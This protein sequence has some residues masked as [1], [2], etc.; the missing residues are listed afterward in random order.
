MCSHKEMLVSRKANG[1]IVAAR[2]A[3]GESQQHNAE[4]KQPGTKE[5]ALCNH[6]KLK[7]RGPNLCRP[8]QGHI[9]FLCVCVRAQHVCSVV[10]AHVRLQRQEGAASCSGCRLHGCFNIVNTR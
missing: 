4:Q 7:D 5:E 10:C 6:G 8:E 1:Q 2:T 3:V 9:V